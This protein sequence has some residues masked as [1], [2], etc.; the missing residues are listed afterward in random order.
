MSQL[1][2]HQAHPFWGVKEQFTP[3]TNSNVSLNQKHFYKHTQNNA[4]P[5]ILVSLSPVKLIHEINVTAR[6]V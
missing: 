2:D 5:N 4:D 6:L 1:K 3:S